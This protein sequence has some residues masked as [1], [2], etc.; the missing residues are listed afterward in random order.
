M[1]KFESSG[2][3]Q[4]STGD[5][6]GWDD[7]IGVK[8]GNNPSGDPETRDAMPDFMKNQPDITFSEGE[9]E[10]WPNSDVSESESESEPEPEPEPPEP[11]EPEEPEPEDE[12]FSKYHP[13]APWDDDM[14]YK[15]GEVE[16]EPFPEW[17]VDGPEGG[18][19]H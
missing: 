1:N 4:D 8:F 3:G 17:Y 6:N 19:E 7:L 18:H 10:P 13:G 14:D 12:L 2:N 16:P 15:E 9:P 5:S 11:P